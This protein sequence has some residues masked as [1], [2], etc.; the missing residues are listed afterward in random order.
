MNEAH[1]GMILMSIIILLLWSIDIDSPLGMIIGWF[2]FSL[3]FWRSTLIS[4]RRKASV[5]IIFSYVSEFPRHPK[6]NIYKVTVSNWC[7]FFHA[8]SEF[9]IFDKSAQSTCPKRSRVFLKSYLSDLF[10]KIFALKREVFSKRSL[11]HLTQMPSGDIAQSVF[12]VSG[13]E[14][15]HSQKQACSMG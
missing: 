14:N 11:S 2:S 13:F 8:E 3:S 10:L 9:S 7:L 15:T 4:V 6:V 12:K 5:V 1:Q